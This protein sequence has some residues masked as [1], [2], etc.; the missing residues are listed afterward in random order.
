[1]TAFLP[2]LRL[3]WRSQFGS[4]TPRFNP[5]GLWSS[6][7]C[8]AFLI[9]IGTELFRPGWPLVVGDIILFFNIVL[10]FLFMFFMV[11]DIVFS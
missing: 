9:E 7:M 6:G 2:Q 4:Y 1:M 3:R 10:V 8:A 5:A 11:S